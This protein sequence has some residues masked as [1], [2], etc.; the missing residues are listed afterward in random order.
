MEHEIVQHMR[1]G[2]NTSESDN[3]D[4][5]V[6]FIHAMTENTTV[7]GRSSSL[8]ILFNTRL[9]CSVFNNEKMLINIQKA[10]RK[11]V[12]NTNGGSHITSM[13]GELLGFL[14]TGST[15]NSW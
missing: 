4:V 8:Y 14:L 1:E 6:S 7:K 5:V 2:D 12:A 15:Q 10:S 3:N 13:E 9:T 11:P